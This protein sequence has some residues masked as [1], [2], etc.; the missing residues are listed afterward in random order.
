MASRRG[1]GRGDGQRGEAVAQV[2]YE[3]VATGQH[4]GRELL[5][6]AHRAQPLLEMPV[7]AFQAAARIYAPHS[8][9]GSVESL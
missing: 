1:R 4:V 9:D 7:V 3:G 6:P 8:H 2:L 5:E